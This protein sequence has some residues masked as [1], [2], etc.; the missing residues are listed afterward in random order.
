MCYYPRYGGDFFMAGFEGQLPKC[1][2]TLIHAFMD[3]VSMY[4]FIN[5][6]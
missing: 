4:F 5:R 2:R 1:F 6:L 3:W